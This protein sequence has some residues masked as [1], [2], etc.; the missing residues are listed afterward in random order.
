MLLGYL[1]FEGLKGSSDQDLECRSLLAEKP[2]KS[3]AAAVRKTVTLQERKKH[4]SFANL[5]LT[6][7]TYLSL[8]ITVDTYLSL[9]I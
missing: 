3:E 5:G 2:E 4:K 7:D 6:V 8:Y 1:G 9:Y